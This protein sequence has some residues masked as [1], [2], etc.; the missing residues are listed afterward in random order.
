M[1]EKMT[2]CE[3]CYYS[4]GC[5]DGKKE[6]V[7]SVCDILQQELYDYSKDINI[8]NYLAGYDDGIKRAIDVLK[9]YRWYDG[10]K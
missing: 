5:A 7:Q 8:T 6:L 3:Q 4:K 10:R 2:E 9:G 1:A